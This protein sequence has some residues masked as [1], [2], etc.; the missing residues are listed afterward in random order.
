MKFII[1]ELHQCQ[2]IGIYDLILISAKKLDIQSDLDPSIRNS[3]VFFPV[4]L[5]EF[6]GPLC[7]AMCWILAPGSQAHPFYYFIWL[8]KMHLYW[9]K[10]EG[11]R[12]STKESRKLK[13]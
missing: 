6:T 9:Q 5:F 12:S 7:L 11:S 10:I 1:N 8:L 4:D 13:N 3:L 2:K